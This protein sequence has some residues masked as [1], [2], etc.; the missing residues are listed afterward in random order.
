MYYFGKLLTDFLF[1]SRRLRLVFRWFRMASA[2]IAN[3]IISNF[4][5]FDGH[6]RW[7]CSKF[8]LDYFIYLLFDLFL[9]FQ[10]LSRFTLS[11]PIMTI[12]RRSIMT[13]FFF[14]AQEEPI[15]FAIL[16][17]RLLGVL[18][19]FWNWNQIMILDGF[20]SRYNIKP[21]LMDFCS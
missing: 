11:P 8:F 18:L 9:I 15:Y 1:F 7:R 12:F 10:S 2:F 16:F 20:R 17:Q 13:N 14:F 6:L 3:Q 21:I 19:Y 4:H 5:Y